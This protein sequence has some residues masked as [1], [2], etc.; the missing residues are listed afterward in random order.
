MIPATLKFLTL[1][2][3]NATLSLISQG[4]NDEEWICHQD[5][6]QCAHEARRVR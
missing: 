3:E 6:N 5:C 2:T 4:D 1:A